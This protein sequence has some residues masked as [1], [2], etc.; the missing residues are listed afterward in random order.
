MLADYELLL[1]NAMKTH[2]HPIR[3]DNTEIVLKM[4]HYLTLSQYMFPKQKELQ[5]LVSTCKQNIFQQNVVT[6]GLLTTAVLHWH[7]S[8]QSGVSAEL[9]GGAL[10]LASDNE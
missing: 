10:P 1:I 7:S 5:D 9:Y 6:E 4:K 8:L 2:K 3:G